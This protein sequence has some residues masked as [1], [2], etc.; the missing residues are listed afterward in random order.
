MKILYITTI[1]GT[2][3]FFKS[4]IRRLLDEGHT[5]E[6]A[7]NEKDSKVPECY[8]E[9]GCAVHG[10][11]TTRF[12]FDLD[13]VRAV[14]QIRKLAEEGK[15]D[16]VHCHTPIAAVC[17]RLACRNVRGKGTEV[18]YTA[19]GFHFYKGGP[20]K[21]WLM[22]YPVE[23]FCSRFTDVLIT[24]NMEDYALARKKMKAGRVEYVPGVG[25]DLSGFGLSAFDRTVKRRELDVPEDAVVLLS[26]GELDATKNHETVIRAIAGL[27]VY[28]LIAGK[29]DLRD[30]LQGVIDGL[31][32]SG[33]VKLLGYR[34]DMAELYRAADVYVLP[35]TREGLNVSVMEAMASG[36]PVA[37]SRIRGNTEMVDENGGA[38]FSPQSV[39]ECRDA[40]RRLSA[41]S[42]L[43]RKMAEANLE[44]VKRFGVI[45]I[46]EQMD[47]LYQRS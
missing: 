40:I 41:D 44:A 18:F 24:I 37:C 38:L 19:H 35:S 13:N 46:N 29:G 7:T 32:L 47:R 4:F 10:I 21:D 2:M 42:C 8:R 43:R 11:D 27:D 5:V 20:L 25:I 12:P 45:R 3:G 1:G 9:W 23:K 26:V 22:Y 30:H 16:I 31:G 33:R 39:E 17:T 28:Y 6:I 36:L 34:T 14:G 15:Y